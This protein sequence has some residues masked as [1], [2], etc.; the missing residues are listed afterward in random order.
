MSNIVEDYNIL[1]KQVAV[2]K[3]NDNDLKKIF[4]NNNYDIVLS[5]LEVEKKIFNN[6][7]YVNNTVI[8]K[9]EAQLKIDE[10]RQIVNEKDMIME[11]VKASALQ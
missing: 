3:V 11:K 10:L 1:R 5:F 6:S 7:T 4:K 9:S 8:T 2:E